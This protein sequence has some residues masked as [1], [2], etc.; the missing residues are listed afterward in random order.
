MDKFI[1]PLIKRGRV[2]IHF[3]FNAK[4]LKKSKPEWHIR[5]AVI[6]IFDLDVM[7]VC[8]TASIRIMRQK[9]FAVI[10]SLLNGL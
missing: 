7:A 10:L 1:H 4:L 9:I 2:F 3:P 8:Q 6:V 5:A